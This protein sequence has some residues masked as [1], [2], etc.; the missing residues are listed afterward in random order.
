MKLRKLYDKPKRDGLYFCL[1][2]AGYLK[3]AK[4][5]DGKWYAQLGTGKEI[6]QGD[7]AKDL[8]QRVMWLDSEPDKPIP[9]IDPK[10]RA[11]I[12][13]DHKYKCECYNDS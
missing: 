13:R 6:P 3:M 11:C 7:L 12:L 8:E 10:I 2:A 4:F 1:S 9:L 5:F